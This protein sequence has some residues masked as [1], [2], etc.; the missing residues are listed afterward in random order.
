MMLYFQ[1]G[2]H[3]VISRRKELPSEHMKCMPGAYATASATS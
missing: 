3:D 1:D 2:G